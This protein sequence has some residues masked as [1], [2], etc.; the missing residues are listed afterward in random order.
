MKTLGFHNEVAYKMKHRKYD[1]I[2]ICHNFGKNEV[3]SD[4]DNVLTT[5]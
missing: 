2:V 1:A 3:A 5:K 4:Y